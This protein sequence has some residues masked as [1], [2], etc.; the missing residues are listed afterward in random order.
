LEVHME[1]TV[2]EKPSRGRLSRIL[3]DVFGVLLGLLFLVAGVCLLCGTAHYIAF[4]GH[5]NSGIG[6]ALGTVALLFLGICLALPTRLYADR[7]L[8]IAGQLAASMTA[9]VTV[10]SVVLPLALIVLLIADPPSPGSGGSDIAGLVVLIT[11]GVGLAGIIIFLPCT[12]ILARK[13]RIRLTH[14]V[15]GTP[16]AGAVG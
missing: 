15:M 3:C 7:R 13:A 2:I 14:L 12:W 5:I 6:C 10:A 4:G 8:R 1:T 16:V 9:A 11:V